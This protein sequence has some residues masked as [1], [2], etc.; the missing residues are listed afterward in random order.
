MADTEY[1]CPLFIYDFSQNTIDKRCAALRTVLF[2]EFDRFIDGYA[3]WNILIKNSLV[4][5]Q[6]QNWML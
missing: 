4:H 2:A 3:D 5:G 1:T 6:P